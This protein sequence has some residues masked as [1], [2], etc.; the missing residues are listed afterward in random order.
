MKE[1]PDAEVTHVAVGEKVVMSKPREEEV[2]CMM[3]EAGCG[4]PLLADCLL[5]T[6]DAADE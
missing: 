2:N 6:S 5:Y 3:E 1:K 4:D